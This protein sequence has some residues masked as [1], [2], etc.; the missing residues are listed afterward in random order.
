[1]T[2][3]LV[4]GDPLQTRA[5]MLAFGYNVRGRSEVDPL[6]TVLQFRHPAAF[7]AFGKQARAGRIKPGMLWVWR[8]SVPYLGFLVIRESS[9]GPVRL[10]HVQTVALTLARDYRLEG[11]TSVA[12]GGLC[13]PAELP[14]LVEV[15]RYWLEPSA[16]AV[17][18]Y[19]E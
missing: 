10:R 5:Q 18:V 19:L 11:Y 1:M 16:L 9:V 17:E 4:S 12:I 13:A 15:L 14:P 3:T 6:H 8:E 2:L 7:A